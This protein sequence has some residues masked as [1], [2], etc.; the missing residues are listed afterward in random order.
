MVKTDVSARGE[1]PPRAGSARCRSFVA[2]EDCRSAEA[3]AA[4]ESTPPKM[5]LVNERACVGFSSA[6]H[7]TTAMS[8]SHEGPPM[9]KV[10]ERAVNDIGI[11][12]GRL[13][14]VSIP[15]NSPGQFC[16]NNC[17]ALSVMA[18]MAGCLILRSAEIA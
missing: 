16:E 5:P 11:G 9:L 13:E 17:R 15:G 18:A 3:R 6:A 14:H 2:N 7:Q 1:P 12:T 10:R 8:A 4:G